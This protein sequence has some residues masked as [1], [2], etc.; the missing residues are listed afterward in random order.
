MYLSERIDWIISSF[1][2]WISKII[3][4]LDSWNHFGNL[5]CKIG[6][7]PFFYDS[8]LFLGSV[9]CIVMK[10]NVKLTICMIKNYCTYVSVAFL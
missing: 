2:R 3:F 4:L 1:P 8:I 6:E 7:C 9:G 5:E 10:K